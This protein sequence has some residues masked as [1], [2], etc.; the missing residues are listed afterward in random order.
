[1]RVAWPSTAFIDE[2]QS[3]GFYLLAAVVIED[4]RMARARVDVESLRLAGPKLHWAKESPHRRAEVL[5]AVVGFGFTNLVVVRTHKVREADERA[6]RLSLRRLVWELDQRGVERA[7]FES[8]EKSQNSRDADL[9]RRLR[10]T[11]ELRGSLHIDHAA[12]R[13]EPLLWLA[14][15][16]AGGVRAHRTGS[17]DF[18]A[19]LK[20]VEL[21]ET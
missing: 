21:I 17:A 12:G 5:A 16:V 2:S 20:R 1:M 18:S 19:L 14:D 10:R 15:V 3:E 11:Q 9:V 7:V 13:S 4:R 8:R 6:R